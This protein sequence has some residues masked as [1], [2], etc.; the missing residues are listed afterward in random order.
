MKARPADFDMAALHAALDAKR[1]ALGLS[2]AGATREINRPDAAPV[3]HPIS[4]SSVTGTGQGRGVEGNIVLQM[5]AWLDRTPESFIPGHP[6]PVTPRTQLPQAPPD[7]RLRW[8]VRALHAALDARR[9]D[10]G[11]TW[12]QVAEEI[13]GFTPSTL[14]GLARVRHVGFPRV[15][16]LVGWLDRPA[17]DFVV[18]RVLRSPAD[19]AGSGTSGHQNA[20]GVR[21]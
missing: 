2:W 16:R 20:T 12:K 9:R 6:A 10:L 18:L 19:Q 8:D 4:V 15:M 1:R 11:M 21:E 3:L 14:T 7:R 5:L 17:A 13:G